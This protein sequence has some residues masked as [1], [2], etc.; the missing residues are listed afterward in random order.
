MSEP[1]VKLLLVDDE[2]SVREPLARHLRAEPYK[3][4]VIDVANADA[5]WRTLEEI[6]GQCDVALIDEV[7]E[8][9]PSGLNLLRQIKTK[10]PKIECV[11]FTGWGMQSGLD[12][13]RAGA[14][15]YFAKPFNLEELALTIRFAAVERQQH[16]EQQFLAAL[17]K[18]SQGLTKTTQQLEQLSLAWDFVREQLDVPTF[19][20]AL[21]AATSDQVYFPLVY[22]GGKQVSLRDVRLGED[23]SNWGL[24]GYI[25]KT[26]E[27]IL[28][29][30]LEE[31]E[32]VCNSRKIITRLVGEPSAS[33]F[34][35]PLVIG[36]RV[37][38]VLS[39]QSYQPGVFSPAL[40]NALRALAGHLSVAFENSHLFAEVEQKAKDNEYQAERISA[41]EKLAININSSME[42]KEVLTKACQVAVDFFHVDHS[43]LVLFNKDFFKV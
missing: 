3:Y 1:L 23:S 35:V 5:A 20:I 12:A 40:Q 24:A 13:L 4:V 43:G 34:C 14:Y 32:Q 11:L 21:Y 30:T 39:A 27:E 36:A 17:V 31:K 22:D 41:L 29:S 7:L 42:T 6:D 38:G 15:R 19:F 25:L 28:W 37:H 2:D 9:G 26:G 8:E 16:M 18:V 33:C 10:Y